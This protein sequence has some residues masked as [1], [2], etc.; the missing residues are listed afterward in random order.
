MKQTAIRILATA[1]VGAIIAAGPTAWGQTKKDEFNALT[2]DTSHAGSPL[3]L[4]KY[5][6]SFR[7]DFKTMSV[8][9]DGGSG[10][11]FAPVHGSF[12]SGRFLPPSSDGPFISGSEGMIIRAEKVD[13][14]WG[15]GLMQTVDGS[16]HGFA[17]RYGY[18]EARIQFPPGKGGWPAFWLLS[19]NGLTDKKATRTEIDIVEW[20]GGDPKG[21]HSSVHLW[22]AAERSAEQLDKHVWRSHYYNMKSALVDGALEGFHTYGA[23]VTPKWVII[24]FDRRETARFKSV[25]EFQTPLYMLVNLAIF[26]KEADV[27]SSPKDLAIQ[28]VAAYALKDEAVAKGEASSREA[29]Q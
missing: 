25:P 8:T 16:G 29:V 1:L 4:T 12:G 5:K 13:G 2:W 11:W 6:Q 3:D 27:A 24:Y 23:E 20:Y 22:P 7:D 14:K 19:Q 17:Q 21:H 26:K 10:P 28:Y 9:P 15:T 18:F